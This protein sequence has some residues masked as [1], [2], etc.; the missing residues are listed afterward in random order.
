MQETQVQSLGQED[1]LEEEMAA[2]S[3]VLA[4]R[5]PWTEEPHGLQSRGP[6]ESDETEHT[7]AHTR[8]PIR[9][10]KGKEGCW[11]QTSNEKSPSQVSGWVNDKVV[12]DSHRKPTL[13]LHTAEDPH[14]TYDLVRLYL[15]RTLHCLFLQLDYFS[16]LYNAGFLFSNMSSLL[17][18]R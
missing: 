14:W 17:S 11:K 2:H 9:H 3:S 5:I 16:C 13:R 1:P 12:S 8:L 6:K 4:W 18:F 10:M 15:P 7:H